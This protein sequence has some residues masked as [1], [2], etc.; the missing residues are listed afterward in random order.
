MA[1]G[2]ASEALRERV[3]RL[4]NFVGVPEDDGAVPLSVSTEQH[5]IELV[6]LRR[7]LDDFMTESSARITNIMEDV[8]A[9][10]DVV[11]INLK[12]LE[13]DVA[14]VKQTRPK[15]EG[16]EKENRDALCIAGED[17]A[18]KGRRDIPCSPGGDQTRHH[19]GSSG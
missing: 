15:Q 7:I 6:D 8:M 17:W 3:S 13:D 11:K 10:T 12:S 5:A 4:E 16:R 14:L 9:L 19:D 1:G 2:T 18:A